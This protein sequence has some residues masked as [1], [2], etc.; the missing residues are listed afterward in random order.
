MK[1]HEY[2]PTNINLFTAIE[3]G[4]VKVNGISYNK[5]IVV[6]PDELQHNWNV[7]TFEELNETHFSCFLALKPEV[8]LLGTGTKQHFPHPSLYRALTN[9]GISVEAMDTHAAC[10]TYNILAA[11]DRKVIAAIIIQE[12]S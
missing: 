8:L 3:P 1:F 9:A 10:H 5:S 6:A 4:S 7:A 11:E 2:N 12:A